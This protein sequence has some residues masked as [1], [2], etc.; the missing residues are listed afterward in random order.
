MICNFAA[1]LGIAAALTIVSTGPPRVEIHSDSLPMRV[2]APVADVRSEPRPAPRAYV[3]DPL[4]ETQLLFGE[5]VLVWEVDGEWARVT[6]PGQME[7]SHHQRWEGYPGWVRL[8]S[9]D[10]VST[11]PATKAV[12]RR[13]WT[14]LYASRGAAA[15]PI[16]HLPLGSF[17]D[18]VNRS[19][20]W[21]EIVFTDRRTAWIRSGDVRLSSERVPKFLIGAEVW[22]NVRKFIGMPY[23]WGGLS[24]KWPGDTESLEA[25]TGVDCSGL[26]HLS[27]RL[28]GLE[29]PR[30]SH[31]QWMASKKIGRGD[32]RRG[33]FVFLANAAKPEKVVHVAMYVGGEFMIEG[34]GT[35]LA[36]RRVT[37]KKK[38]GKRLENLESG[39]R[40]GEKIVYFG[41]AGDGD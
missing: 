12:V 41:R 35:G 3:H 1:T 8:A 4:Q 40:V 33:D 36:V 22:K 21:C 14:P 20:D 10:K 11:T 29:I 39:D 23:Y 34:P 26:M 5:P 18:I 27:Y 6:S 13:N 32:L 17:V 16:L 19:G 38:L 37:F 30:D 9:L 7:Y 15:S 2:V 25:V 28:A 31:E 24:P